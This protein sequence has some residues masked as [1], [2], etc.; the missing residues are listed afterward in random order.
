M[1]YNFRQ[2]LGGL[3]GNIESKLWITYII[4]FKLRTLLYRNNRSSK[5]KKNS[6]FKPNFKQI[7]TYHWRQEGYPINLHTGYILI[8][9]PHRF[10]VP[11][12]IHC[13]YYPSFNF[14][15]LHPKKFR[16]HRKLS[17]YSRQHPIGNC[18]ALLKVPSQLRH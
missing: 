1:D 10:Y 9:L 11:R 5:K 4:V 13:A 18:T 8:R 6:Q 3:P 14:I 2:V 17:T 12:V 16:L 7:T 15:T